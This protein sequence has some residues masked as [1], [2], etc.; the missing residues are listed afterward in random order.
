MN[1]KSILS[2]PSG[3]SCA[4]TAAVGP[5]ARTD[6]GALV[7]LK[8]C[9]RCKAK[10]PR[11][12]FYKNSSKK[13][14]L[15]TRCRYCVR[16]VVKQRRVEKAEQRARARLA[17]LRFL[18]RCAKC[19]HEKPLSDFYLQRTK[20]TIA[21]SCKS[22]ESKRHREAYASRKDK[23]QACNKRWA[24]ANRARL[25]AYQAEWRRSQKEHVR[26]TN[27]AAYARNIERQRAQKKIWRDKNPEKSRAYAQTYLAAHP[28]KARQQARLRVQRR[29][30]LE[31]KSP[32]ARYLTAEH[33][34]AR[35]AMWGNRCYA[36][37]APATTT[38]HVIALANGGTNWPANLRPM[39]KPCNAKKRISPLAEFMSRT[40]IQFWAPCNP[41]LP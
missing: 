19:G 13:D 29:R 10:L 11:S 40:D 12:A 31:L 39:C 6:G 37:G 20:K 32:G 4:A 3:V 1:T 41:R 8:Q 38:D 34:K 28:E 24:A 17:K 23:I 15:Q 18:K 16:A 5:L 36:C 2:P 14:G 30:C 25:R 35:W 33:I 9:N 26:A 27:R 7:P 21:S 22:C